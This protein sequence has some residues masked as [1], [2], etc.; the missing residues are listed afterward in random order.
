MTDGLPERF[1]VLVHP[2]SELRGE[3]RA[4]PSKNYTTRYLLAAALAEGETRVVGAATSEDAEALIRC[5][6]A[7]GADVDRVGEDVVV[8]GFG[9]HPRAGMTLN[10]GNAGAVARFLMGVAALTT[11]TTFVTD[12]SESLGRRPQGD[13]LAALERLG[14]RV[15]SRNGQLPVTLSGPVRGG[16]VEVSAQRSSQYASALMFLGPLLPDGLDLRLTGEIKSHAPLRQTLDTLAAFGLQARASADLTRITIPGGQAYRPGRVLVPGDYPGSAALLVAAAL[17]PGEVTVT[18]LREGDLQGEREALNVLRAMGA[19]LV[20]EGDR[21]TV[22][23][24]RPLHAVT[25]DGDSFTDAVQ[26]L[27]AAAAFARG[28]TT[29]ENVATLRLKECDRISDTRRELERLGLTATETADSLS[30]TGADRIPGDLTADGHGDHRMI[31]LLTLLGLRAEAPLRITG[32]HHIRKS[33][34]LFFRHL[35]ELGAHFEYLPTDAA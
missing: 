10:P 35:E 8:R 30:I 29:W 14:A 25:R 31:M 23:G 12:Y 17:L 2:V 26:A 21:V 3:L 13:L 27:T 20:R 5:L 6:R 15:S 9:A 32:A 1:D 22:R 24:G 18:N 16:R 4:Q 34:P 11:D 19:D 33:Y 7:W 28:T